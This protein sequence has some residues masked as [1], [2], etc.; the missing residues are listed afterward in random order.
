MVKGYGLMINIYVPATLNMS[1]SIHMTGA[2]MASET[3]R[4]R[5]P[6]GRFDPRWIESIEKMKKELN[7]YP[8]IDLNGW[9]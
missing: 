9:L 1:K 8:D 6:Y 5:I 2:Y 7:Q 4:M 3:K